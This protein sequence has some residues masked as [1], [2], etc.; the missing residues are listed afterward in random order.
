MHSIIY[1]FIVLICHPFL[2]AY[3]TKMY[4]N[5][6]IHPKLKVFIIV[7]IP[8]Y[9]IWETYKAIKYWLG[10]RKATKNM[11]KQFVNHSDPAIKKSAFNIANR[12]DQF[13]ILV[14]WD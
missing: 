2:N 1:C 6:S 8:L 10:A 7:I 13:N 11:R 14:L 5:D 12:M 4:N 3:Y 9:N